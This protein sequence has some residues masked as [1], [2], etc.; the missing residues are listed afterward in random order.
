MAVILNDS[1][2][3]PDNGNSTGIELLNEVCKQHIILAELHRHVIEA[4][5]WLLIALV[6]FLANISALYSLQKKQKFRKTHRM[7]LYNVF[8]CNLTMGSVIYVSYVMIKFGYNECAPRDA[9]FVGLIIFTNV[10]Q[11]SMICV[12]LFQLKIFCRVGS[13]QG[14]IGRNTS[15][16]FHKYAIIGSWLFSV[17]IVLLMVF[18]PKSEAILLFTI[19]KVIVI[20]LLSLYAM[21]LIKKSFSL[22]VPLPPTSSNDTENCK[23]AMI[24][25]TTFLLITI[26]TWLPLL[27]VLALQKFEVFPRKTLGV[28]LLVSARIVA[29]GPVIDPMFYFW[30]KTT[31][32]TASLRALRD[33]YRRRTSKTKT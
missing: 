7:Y 15:Y 22:R 31:N 3:H 16:L 26:I 12:L 10:N 25:L 21:K 27:V 1:N 9:C 19:L 24:I 5:F 28:P 11:V 14:N 18:Y 13:L 32:R 8:L 23:I 29:L 2:P 30:S 20:F 4:T 17:G 33:R 6:S